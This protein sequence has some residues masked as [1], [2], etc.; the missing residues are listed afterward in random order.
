M[1]DRLIT[2]SYCYM[3]AANFLLAFSFWQ[4]IPIFPFFLSDTFQTP[5]AVIGLVISCYM[6]SCLC[7]RP[8][9]GYLVDSFA[10]KPLYIFAYFIF[11]CIFGGYLFANT[12]TL[13]I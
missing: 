2:P 8:F 4:L 12:L 10:R 6:V 7:I 1:K 13:F 9:S 3:L 11:A 5:E